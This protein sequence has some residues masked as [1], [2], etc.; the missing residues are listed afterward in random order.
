MEGEGIGCLRVIDP[1]E[2]RDLLDGAGLEVV[3]VD[4][5]HVGEE[6]EAVVGADQLDQT[7]VGEF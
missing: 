5:A 6:I 4:K 2:L 1:E 3:V 7:V